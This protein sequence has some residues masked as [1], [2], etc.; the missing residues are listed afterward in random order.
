MPL[1]CR[2]KDSREMVVFSD[3]SERETMHVFPVAELNGFNPEFQ[4]F[5]EVPYSAVACTDRNRVVAFGR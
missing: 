4:R 1:Y 2:L 5:E 3:N